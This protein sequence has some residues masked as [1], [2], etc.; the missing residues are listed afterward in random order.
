[1]FKTTKQAQ[2]QIIYQPMAEGRQIISVL[3]LVRVNNKRTK[4]IKEV[5]MYP[6]LP[7]TWCS[8]APSQS[9]RSNSHPTVK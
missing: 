3:H 4:V 2:L 6:V 9:G 8:R 7:V 5:A 1:M